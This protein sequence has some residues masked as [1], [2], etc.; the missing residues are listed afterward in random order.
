MVKSLIT[1]IITAV[2]LITACI[3]ENNFVIKQFDEFY[4]EV[5]TVSEKVNEKSAT[6]DDVYSLQKSWLDKKAYLHVFI[7]HGEIKE[8]E[9][10][11]SE[12]IKLVK[13]QKWEDAETKFE[14][15]KELAEQMPYYFKVTWQNIL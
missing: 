8:V 10:W 14:V 13:N 9:L 4:S 11:L 7:P 5:D 3:F 2:L 6:E 1:V 15:L 12:A